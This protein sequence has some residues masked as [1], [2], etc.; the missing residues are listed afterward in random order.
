VAVRDAEIEARR[1]AADGALGAPATVE[2]AMRDYATKIDARHRRAGRKSMGDLTSRVRCHVVDDPI[3]SIELAKLQPEDLSAWREGLRAK[4]P[5]E[6]SIRRTRN[7]L[8]AALNAAAIPHRCRLPADFSLIVRAGFAR[9]VDEPPALGSRPNI[10]LPDADVR[11]LLDASRGI[12]ERH[13]WDG[14]L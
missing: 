11:A 7:D 2:G 14:D 13:G 4:G 12:D 9:G 6:T 1:Q 8:R 3:A 10:I 5:V